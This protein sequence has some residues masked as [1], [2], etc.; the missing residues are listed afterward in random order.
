MGC[1]LLANLSLRGR[2][3]VPTRVICAHFARVARPW[4]GGHVRK[5]D[6]VAAF[7]RFRELL[8]AD[9]GVAA[10]RCSEPSSAT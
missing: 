2:S 5:T 1:D 7:T 4:G 10:H 3:T 9:V 6:V 8:Q